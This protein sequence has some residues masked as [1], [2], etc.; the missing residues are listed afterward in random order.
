MDVAPGVSGSPLLES[1]TTRR[2][3]GS[4]SVTPIR[5]I[6]PIASQKSTS[7]RRTST[8]TPTTPAVSWTREPYVVSQAPCRWL[9]RRSV[10]AR[11]S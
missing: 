1:S 9:S 4:R 8:S 2:P 11:T 3:R 6:F 7:S 5:S 10:G